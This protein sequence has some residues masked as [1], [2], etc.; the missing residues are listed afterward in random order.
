MVVKH[1]QRMPLRVNNK[2]DKDV[3]F[4]VDGGVIVKA[5][6]IQKAPE[7]SRSSKKAA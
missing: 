7:R 5:I 1:F 2:M 6:N 3:L 4:A